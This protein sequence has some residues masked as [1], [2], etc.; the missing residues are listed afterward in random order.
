MTTKNIRNFAVIAHIDHGK[1]TLSDRLIELGSSIKLR[2]MKDQV[3]DSLEIERQRGITIK[4][5]TVRLHYTYKE[6]DYCLNLIDTPG[7]VDFSYEVSRSLTACEG[8]ILIVDATQGVEAQTLSNV[9]K[10]IDANHEIIVVLN[11]VDL[12]SANIEAVKSDIEDTIG[13]DTSTA[14]EV[15]AK[16][17]VGVPQLLDAIVNN[18]PSPQGNESNLL[19][20][21]LVDAW[22]DPYVGIIILIRVI[23]GKIKGNMNIKM[24]SSGA[25]YTV[26]KVGIFLP[27]KHIVDELSAGEIGFFTASIKVLADCKIGDTIVSSNDNTSE[28]IQGFQE[29]NQVVFC[30]FF[31]KYSDDYEDLKKALEKLNLNDTSFV[32]ENYSSAGLGYGF[33]CGF[34]GMLHLEVISERLEKEYDI[35][36]IV[37]APSVKYHLYL[38]P[39]N[40]KIDIQNANDFPD[41]SVIDSIEEPWV[42]ATIMSPVEY[43]G[44]VIDLC[45]SKRGE[46]IKTQHIGQR[47]V[48][49]YQLPLGEIVFEFYDMLK[50]LSKGYASVEWQ[51]TDY[52]SSDIVKVNILVNAESVEALTF[53]LHSTNAYSRS[54]VICER[55]KESIPRKQYK[56]AIQAAIGGK[57]IARET[58]Q[59]FRKDVTAKLYGGD[60][61]RKMKLLEK[62]KK[63]KKRMQ[64]T[65]SVDVPH[66]ALISVFKI[67]K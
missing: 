30:G 47:V 23:D 11:K 41:P 61:T 58:I 39:D 55:L 46:H 38:K 54:K 65:G 7:H 63:G 14:L 56:I 16:T 45:R 19:R 2:N 15:S 35:D 43:M 5:Q 53:L 52:R 17:G 31:P 44:K 42:E 22:Y 36:V 62:Q 1:S 50:S 12:P 51:L 60:K 40:K 67:K 26:D 21:L 59:A 6:I 3:L 33:R 29:V 48:L 34:L 18:I 4:A 20:I 57:I 37:T 24:L 49:I 27:D 28:V 66:S 32:Y 10:A 64:M 8:S 25:I 9:Y 13:I